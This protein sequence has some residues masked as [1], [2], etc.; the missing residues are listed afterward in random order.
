MILRI[1]AEKRDFCLRSETENVLKLKESLC[2]WVAFVKGCSIE[3]VKTVPPLAIS[4]QEVNAS[5]VRKSEKEDEG[6]KSP[7]RVG[8]LL[9][10]AS[11]FLR[12]EEKTQNEGAPSATAPRKQVHNV[13]SSRNASRNNSSVVED[14]EELPSSHSPSNAAIAAVK[15]AT[16]QS[17]MTHHPTTSGWLYKLN[18]KFVSRYFVLEHDILS[19]FASEIT[20][21]VG[22]GFFNID[23]LTHCRLVEPRDFGP[24]QL[25]CMELSFGRD[26][27]WLLGSAEEQ[28]VKNWLH[29]LKSRQ[30]LSMT[31]T[32]KKSVLFESGRHSEISSDVGSD[33]VARLSVFEG[34]K[35]GYD[36]LMAKPDFRNSNATDS[37]N[38]HNTIWEDSK[39][40]E[41]EQESNDNAIAATVQVDDAGSL[42]SSL[43]DLMDLP[44]DDFYYKVEQMIEAKARMEQ[45]ETEEL[46]DLS[47]VEMALRRPTY[48][49]VDMILDDVIKRQVDK[50]QSKTSM[51]AKLFVLTLFFLL[52]SRPSVCC[53]G[54]SDHAFSCDDIDG[55]KESKKRG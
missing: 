40:E 34:D 9:G 17:S 51:R 38:V 32:V 11:S 5:F 25:Y 45:D 1:A 18:E 19:Y 46:N 42:L 10:K 50:A 39:S 12:K 3:E 37:S 35:Q 16:E 26:I 6:P 53:R 14:L 20:S 13:L 48:E 47:T 43:Q 7:G 27:V 55:C 44:E 8:M 49:N 22:L 36:Q 28:T 52:L 4:S 15:P 24:L 41:V 54:S 23:Q 31:S 21:G 2:K 29:V 33:V 30:S